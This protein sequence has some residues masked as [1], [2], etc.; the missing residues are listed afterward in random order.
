[1]K[2]IYCISA[3]LVFAV[4]TRADGFKTT[5]GKDYKNVK[6]SRVE[7]DGIV[8]SFSGGIVKIPFTELPSDVQKKYGYDLKAAEAFQHERYEGDVTRLRQEAE[9]REKRQHDL[10]A[11]FVKGQQDDRGSDHGQGPTNCYLEVTNVSSGLEVE[12]H[13]ET[14]WGSY[15]R[16]HFGRL[17]LKIR[18]GTVG[19]TGGP[20]KIQ[21][22]WIGRPLI[23]M[24]NLILYGQG[25][26]IVSVPSRYFVECYAAA[27]VLKSH[28]LNLAASGKRYVSGAQHDGWIVCASD[29]KG[30]ILAEKASTESL[31]TLFN[32]PDRFSELPS[33][34]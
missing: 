26:K 23:N 19:A 2:L 4:L 24:S 11:Y 9:A 1:M 34:Q 32:D 29:S 14:S 30:R 3:L 27:P 15:D 13:W 31:L 33:P 17:I 8:I 20:M 12:S 16:D 22:F 5:E 7:P 18:L 21:W 28:V 6:V 25:E 10:E